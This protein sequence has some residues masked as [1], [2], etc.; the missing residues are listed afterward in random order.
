MVVVVSNRAKSWVNDV[1]LHTKAPRLEPLPSA[2]SHQPFP[3]ARRADTP[4]SMVAHPLV[5]Y[6][7]VNLRVDPG[8]EVD[9]K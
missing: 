2:F 7:E 1:Q 9:L 6:Y 3:R 5:S 4:G 8:L